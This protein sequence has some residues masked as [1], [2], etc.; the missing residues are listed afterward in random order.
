MNLGKKGIDAFM[1]MV[2]CQTHKLVG[3]RLIVWGR[4]CGKMTVAMPSSPSPTSPCDTVGLHHWTEIGATG[5][6]L[7]FQGNKGK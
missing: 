1:A 2:R 6:R 3:D 7:L 5:T 4:L